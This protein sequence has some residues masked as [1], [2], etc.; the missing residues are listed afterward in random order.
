[1]K[2][3]KA[4]N[5][6]WTCR[7]KQYKIGE[8]FEEDVQLIPCESGMHFCE[9]MPNVFNFY[10]FDPDQTVVAEVEALG[11]VKTDDDIKFCTNKLLIIRELSWDEVQK[12]CNTG[13][14]NTGNC[15]TGNCNTGDWN[16]AFGSSGCFNTGEPTITMFN[17]PSSWTLRDWMNSDARYYLNQIPK[18]V[19][20]WVWSSDMT[21]KEKKEHPEYKT[22]D[23]YL[24]VLDES[25]CAQIWWDGVDEHVHGIIKALPNFDA[26]IFE[27]CTGIKI[28]EDNEQY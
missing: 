18:N 19:V 12:G 6:D 11:D 23:G 20:E 10:T 5:K 25:E 24:K 26:A 2:G 8:T 28:G 9:L 13:D 7:G 27:K 1:M 17:K 4:F 14:R 3:Y 15:N 22:T 16:C 21:D